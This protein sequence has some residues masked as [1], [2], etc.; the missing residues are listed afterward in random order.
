V[1]GNWN[2]TH[3]QEKHELVEEAKQYSQDV[4]GIP[5]SKPRV[6]NPFKHVAQ[7]INSQR[8]RGPPTTQLLQY[9]NCCTCTE[10]KWKQLLLT[11]RA[12]QSKRRLS[13]FVVRKHRYSRLNNVQVT[14]S[15]TLMTMISRKIRPQ[16][17]KKPK[18][19][20]LQ[21]HIVFGNI[22]CS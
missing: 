18:Q 14:S 7:L 8:V 9:N 6:L 2:I 12:L 5:S 15:S 21:F 10:Q 11:Q 13:M 3:S 17:E 19:I 20:V 22:F 1:I 16:L 4:V